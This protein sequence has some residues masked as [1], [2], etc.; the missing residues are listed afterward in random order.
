MK[1]E[2][3]YGGFKMNAST[4]QPVRIEKAAEFIDRSVWAVYQKTRNNTIPFHRQGRI[5]YFFPSELENWIRQDRVATSDELNAKA[6]AHVARK[7]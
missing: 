3:F 6:A 1:R 5:L 7:G 4:E 2:I